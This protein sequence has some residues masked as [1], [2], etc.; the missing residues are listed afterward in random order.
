MLS[1]LRV[2]LLAFLSSVSVHALSCHPQGDAGYLTSVDLHGR[3]NTTYGFSSKSPLRGHPRLMSM[4]DTN[5]TFQFY[6][7]KPPSAHYKPGGQIRS[8]S[9]SSMCLTPGV[10]YR[11]QL[12]DRN[13][14]QY[15]P[16]ADARITLQPCADEANL[17]LRKQ[18]FMATNT[19]YKCV[20]HIS[21]QGWSSDG[22]GDIV[23][24]SDAGVSLGTHYFDESESFFYLVSSKHG[25]CDW[26]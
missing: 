11:Y 14:T 24:S 10:V 12:G 8:T 20:S 4:P 9:N 16:H 5:Q 22:A 25:V 2:V 23:R 19:N 26:Q 15:P 3:H 6:A 1:W 7:C 17:E 18:W 13:V 21:Q